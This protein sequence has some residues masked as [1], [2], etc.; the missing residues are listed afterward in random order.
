V[1]RAALPIDAV[2]PE[3]MAALRA[4]PAA[5]LRAP[6][7][8]GKTTR[9][10]PALLDAGLAGGGRIVML[11]PR[12]LAAR[13]A[14]RRMA[15]ER[16]VP[17]G[18]E[19]GYQVRF[20]SKCGPRTRIAVVTPGV[21]LR[22][23]HDDP[24][25]ESTSIVIFDEFHERGLDGDLALGMV[26]LVQQTVRPELRVVVMSATIATDA[27][28]AYLG[29]CPV[30]ASEGRLFPVEI[31]YE[32]RPPHESLP[33]AT[34]GAVR[35]LLGRSPGDVLVFLPG[36]G[37]IRQT[38]RELEPLA[39]E[40]DLAVLPLHGDLP[41]EQQDAALF[42]QDRRKVV[43][44]TNVAETSV[45]VEGVTGVVDTGL[46]RLLTFDP[47]VGL[48]RLE[49]TPISRASADQRAGRAGRLSPGVCVRLWAESA[50]R[51]RP[52]QT[53]PEIRR[54][55]LAGA[56]LHLLGLGERHPEYFPWLDPPPAAAVAQALDL[57]RLLGALDANGLA[58]LGQAMARLPVHPR[59]ARLLI[60]GK[61]LGCPER[62][63]LAAALLA[64]R[65][66]FPRGFTA[67][68]STSTDSDVADR[69]EAL[70]E[71]ERT[72]REQTPLGPLHRQGARFVL[73]AR[74]QLLRMVEENPSPGPSPKR[75]GEEGTSP[76]PLREGGPGGLGSDALARALFAAFPDRLARRRNPGGNRGVMVG[77]RGVKLMPSSRVHDFELF[78]C[79]DVDAGAAEA[80]V[81][82][83]SG[84]RREWLP[85][86]RLIERTSVE[87]NPHTEKVEARRTLRFED[88]LLEANP[89]L[90]PDED[91]AARALAD[92]ALERF[93]RVRP[94]ADSPAGQYLTR[95]RC[96][97]EWLPELDLPAFAE[98]E[99]RE[100][101]AWLCSGRR[102]LEEVRK[103]DW[104]GAI[105][106]R[107]THAQRQAV[108][109]EAPE[110]I[111]VPSGS[112]IAV[113][114]VE[115]RPPVLAVRIQEMFGLADTPRVAAGRVRVL[116]HLLAPN[117]RPQQVTDDL[118]SFWAN[119][120][121]TVRKEL[122]ARYPKHA[123]P[124]DP[125][126]A[127]AVRGPKRKG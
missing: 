13:A 11:E 124:E 20:D 52:E 103:A 43:L 49:V 56:M 5:V 25:L 40:R 98:T 106:G 105:Q 70:E 110:R 125:L 12:R 32:P 99:L 6:T 35:R 93:D 77:G 100:M 51:A 121:P 47:A 46:A 28:S 8:A 102:S 78:L 64:E 76:F 85:P 122:R 37:E 60:E 39:E 107:L 41:L 114:Y 38:E 104:L 22:I 82:V 36:L 67:P 62:S 23:L 31:R 95:L 45:T 68:S 84:V 115:G 48:D 4:G 111:E 14:A 90:L 94:A 34:A 72:G 7:G 9:V 58:E 42:P 29:G 53:D 18:G 1:S 66:P 15:D 126:K 83:A 50:H 26:R 127:P 113:T 81:R 116:L 108:E 19:V 10:P 112:Q 74:D 92:A 17:L 24:F 91:A 117:F 97:R 79:I 73:R 33:V 30:I 27:V 63:A 21:L 59:L 54:V 69:V 119:T 118:A 2:L 88:L 80:L 3:L 65:D 87:F 55:D 96:L 109:R 71:F 16:G 86:E 44:A 89:V 61:A 120:Y 101:L 75:G 123:W 57:L